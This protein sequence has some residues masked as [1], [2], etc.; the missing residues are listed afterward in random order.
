LLLSFSRGQPIQTTR[1]GQIALVVALS[2]DK[3]LIQT[4]TKRFR[5]IEEPNHFL[6]PMEWIILRDVSN[7]AK[8]L[9]NSCIVQ[10]N[11]IVYLLN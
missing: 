8:G 2:K 1:M 6:I 10:V 9:T 5:I 4:L 7:M 3:V 11:S